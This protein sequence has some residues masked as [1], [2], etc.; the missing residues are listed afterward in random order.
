MMKKHRK[1]TMLRAFALG[2]IDFL[3]QTNLFGVGIKEGLQRVPHYRRLGYERR[4]G[5]LFAETPSRSIPRLSNRTLEAKIERHDAV[6]AGS[7]LDFRIKMPDGSIQDFVVTRR[8]EFP[9]TTGKI[10]NIV[11]SPAHSSRYFY[12][13]EARFEKG[14]YGWGHMQTAWRGKLFIHHSDSDKVEFTIPDGEFNGRYCIRSS[15][16]RDGDKSWFI[17][18]MKET[19]PAPFWRERMKFVN[20]DKAREQAYLDPEY[21]AE[22]KING[23]HYYLIP[24]KKGN[25]VISRRISVKGEPICRENNIPWLRDLKIPKEYYGRRVHVEVVTD[26]DNPSRTAGFLNASPS[27]SLNNQEASKSYLRAFVLDV[28]PDARRDEGYFTRTEKFARACTAK[29]DLRP[30]G[31]ESHRF[32]LVRT[33]QPRIIEQPRNNLASGQRSDDFT[34]KIKSEGG[35]GTVLKKIDGSYYEDPFIKDKRIDTIDLRIIG[36]QQGTGK[37][38]ERLGALI[39][40]DPSTGVIT[41]VGTG[42]SDDMRTKIWDSQDELRGKLVEVDTNWK[43]HTGAYHGPRFKGFHVESGVSIS[44]E[45]NLIDY[46]EALSEPGEEKATLYRLKSA[47]GWRRG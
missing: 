19:D 15:V 27:T 47:A 12:E 11:R 30:Y 42:F 46:A 41:K 43:I 7:H 29:R 17:L 35:E 33:T 28:E 14:E 32:L 3:G 40:E 6:R 13:N 37:H 10:Y 16:N 2:M 36:F 4:P 23:A 34:R 9:G 25:L 44:D 45:Q 21:I 39:C 38:N 26:D 8:T 18:R 22:E 24:G 31:V 1:N 5:F 20:T